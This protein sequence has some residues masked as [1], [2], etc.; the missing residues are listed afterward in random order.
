MAPTLFRG[1]KIA[2][3]RNTVKM[4]REW[5]M[6]NDTNPRISGLLRWVTWLEVLIL[7]WA[8]GGL[9][10]HPPVIQ[11][12]W[13]WSLTPFNL[14]YL[15]A[16][17]TAAL[18]AALLQAISGRWSPARVVTPMIF[19]FTLVVTI[20]SF[21]HLDRFDPLRLETWI[22]FVLYI[23]VCANAGAHWWLYRR[24][25]LPQ[26][27][28]RPTGALRIVLLGVVGIAGVYGGLLLFAPSAAAGF[29]P[30]A[31]DDFHA[32]LYSVTFL[33]PALG[34]WVLL[35]GATPG[36]QRALGLT[37]AGW[38]FLPM[39]GLVLA[40]AMV[41]RIRWDGVDVWLWLATF[42]AMGI[43]GAWIAMNFQADR[44]EWNR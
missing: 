43:A 38:G 5:H 40:D 36:E 7:T 19:I 14:R 44:T 15:G 1:S 30:W 8:G 33:T 24:L 3:S 9:L 10:L 35:R 22:W 41:K 20:Y 17:Y 23:G 13:P 21:V 6:N 26:P 31:L 12:F 42:A 4:N 25:P 37:L 16:L 11:P 29:W 2:Q 32:H 28:I 18:I 27:G 34:A 39:L